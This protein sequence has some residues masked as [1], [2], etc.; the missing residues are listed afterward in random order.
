MCGE[1][2]WPMMPIPPI[3]IPTQDPFPQPPVFNGPKEDK[4]ESER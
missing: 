1:C 4:D 2:D 3:N